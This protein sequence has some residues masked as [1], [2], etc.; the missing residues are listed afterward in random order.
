[1][2]TQRRD[3]GCQLPGPY[4]RIDRI[5]ALDDFD[6]ETA[7]ALRE[8][9]RIPGMGETT[10]RYFRDK[11]A[12]RARAREYGVPVP[13]FTPVFN[14]EVVNAYLAEV[15]GPWLVKPRSE[16]STI[17]IKRTSSPDEVWRY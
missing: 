8:H 12:M 5:V 7:A 13:P 4:H 6:V 11:L 2:A 3:F 1:M 17:G 10:A 14:D 16:A 15:P 9:L